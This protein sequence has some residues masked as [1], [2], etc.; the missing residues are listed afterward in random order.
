MKDERKKA[1]PEAGN[2]YR[3]EQRQVN[4]RNLK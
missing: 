4:I 3:I 1:R 2:L